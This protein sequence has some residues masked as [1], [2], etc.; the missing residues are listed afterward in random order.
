[1]EGYF[2]RS[3]E[4][5]ESAHW[6][7]YV[8][9]QGAGYPLVLG[10]LRTLWADDGDFGWVAGWTQLL[11]SMVALAGM[12]FL[13]RQVVG[14]RGS[15]AALALGAVHI[16]WIFFNSV[17]MPEALYTMALAGLGVA[18]VRLAR[19]PEGSW[20]AALLLGFFGGLAA[21]LKS[22]HLLVGPFAALVWIFPLRRGFRGAG[23]ILLGWFAGL[24]L[25]FWIPHGLLSTR[26]SGRAFASP[27][28]GGLNFVEGKC[29][30]KENID[31]TGCRYWSP[32]FV[33]QGVQNTKQW[34]KPFLDQGYFFR[35]GLQCIADRP[36]VL[37]ESLEGIWFLFSGN[38]LWPANSCGRRA[39]SL[40]SAW[41][42]LFNGPLAV[43]V[44]LA[45]GL[46]LWRPFRRRESGAELGDLWLV[47]VAPVLALFA[48]VWLFKSEIRYRMPFDIFLIPLALWGLKESGALIRARMGWRWGA[49]TRAVP[50]PVRPDLPEPQAPDFSGGQASRRRS[51]LRCKCRKSERTFQAIDGR[52]PEAP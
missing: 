9:F 50:Y 24:A 51:F 15:G 29:P 1:M 37:L 41:A 33:Q 42:K 34:A 22:A 26:M 21:W 35:Q 28:S 8:F 43:G 18:L 20:G 13:S 30:W 47:L 17:Y 7:P 23:R 6:S 40:S 10:S 49:Q 19:A 3:K 39:S 5:F 12:V 16:P 11:A 46:A 36:G 2:A 44:A 52:R 25:F 45:L 27:P 32:L 38:E 31:S 14:R 48:T 4:M